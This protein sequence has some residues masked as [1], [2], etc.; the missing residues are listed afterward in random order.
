MKCSVADST[1]YIFFYK[2]IKNSATLYKILDRYEI[3][4]GEILKKEISGHIGSDEK[5]HSLIKD[6]SMDVDFVSL[7]EGYLDIAKILYPQISK[8]ELDGE[9]EAIGISYVL[10]QYK[11]LQYLIIDDKRVYNFIKNKL[12]TIESSLTRTVN[13]LYSACVCDNELDKKEV[14]QIYD[15][16]L[17]AITEGKSPFYLTKDLWY[18]YVKPLK[19]KCMGI[20]D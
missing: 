12:I 8:W 4:I 18:K 3:F 19:D 2:E 1:F 13:F 7:L 11:T 6:I 9:F 16:I 17:I 10:N 5:F 20:C 15:D 14:I